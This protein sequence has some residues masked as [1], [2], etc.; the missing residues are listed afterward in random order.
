MIVVA[1]GLELEQGSIWE[2]SVGDV[3][4]TGDYTCRWSQALTRSER[5][6]RTW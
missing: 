3:A 4:Q 1:E 2:G 6:F 5:M